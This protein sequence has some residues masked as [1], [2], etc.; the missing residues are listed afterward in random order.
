MSRPEYWKPEEYAM[1]WAQHAL[2]REERADELLHKWA[3]T[4]DYT[5]RHKWMLA[6]EALLTWL[7]KDDQ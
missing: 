4:Y 2:D 1:H 6:V 5:T 7:L 3:E